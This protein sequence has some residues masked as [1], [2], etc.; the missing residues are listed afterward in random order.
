LAPNFSQLKVT[1]SFPGLQKWVVTDLPPL[2]ESRP[3]IPKLRLKEVRELAP[4]IILS[5]PSC[6]ICGV[7]AP[8]NLEKLDLAPPG[9][10]DGL[11]QDTNRSLTISQV[12]VE[13]NRAMVDVLEYFRLVG[14]LETPPELGYMEDIVKIRQL[15]G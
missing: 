3:E 6:F 1:T 5:L 11:L 4:K 7:I 10:S 8:L 15:F 2:K 12:L 14:N 13:I 9:E